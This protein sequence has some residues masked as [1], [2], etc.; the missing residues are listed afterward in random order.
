MV[1]S[2][3]GSMFLL[4]R[5]NPDPQGSRQSPSLCGEAPRVPVFGWTN[6]QMDKPPPLPGHNPGDTEIQRPQRGHRGSPISVTVSH[7]VR[8]LAVIGTSQQGPDQWHIHIH[9]V[10]WPMARPG[11]SPCPRAGWHGG[12]QGQAGGCSIQR[13]LVPRGRAPTGICRGKSRRKG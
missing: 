1:Q 3:A 11:M 13:G 8:C 12:I 2:V 7:C 4:L 10:T 5:P 6:L 9:H